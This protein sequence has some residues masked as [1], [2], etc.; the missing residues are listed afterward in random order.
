MPFRL[1]THV[2]LEPG[3]VAELS[4][5]MNRFTAERAM[6]LYDPGLAK[7]KWP[8]I[9]RAQLN[10]AGIA[11][12]EFDDIEPNPRVETVDRAARIARRA[13]LN[14]IVGIGGGSVLDAAKAVSMLIRNRG[15]ILKYEGR[16]LFPEPAAPFIAIPTTCGTGSEVTWVSVL[17]DPISRR[18]ISIKG[19]GMFPALAIVDADVLETLPTTLIAQTGI[20]ALTHAVETIIGKPANPVSDVLAREAVQLLVEH[21][22][23]LVKTPANSVAREAVMRAST[24]AGM[25]FGNADVGAVHCLSES[26]GGLTDL[27][28]GLLNAVLI[29]PVLTYELEAIREPLGSIL[30]GI[31]A[32]AML[33]IIRDIVTDAGIPSFAFL[34]INTNLYE[35]L[36]VQAAQNGSNQSN[37][38]T[39]SA[40]NYR[41]ILDSL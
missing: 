1:P 40:A 8:A 27:G 35:E 29:A 13:D 14:L 19:D 26:I 17:S 7:T 5:Y 20:D 28:H 3:S 22:P 9:V 21:L 36:S 25:A 39:M 30:P 33:K 24:L 6:L 31:N 34:E 4:R 32:E 10:D 23:S 37:R 41:Q 12:V 15:D 11:V 16:N 2:V 18:K 38:K